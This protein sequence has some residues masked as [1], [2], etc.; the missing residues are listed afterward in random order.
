MSRPPSR[1]PLTALL[2]LALLGAPGCRR[3][4]ALRR[5]E[6]RFAG[7][8]LRVDSFAALKPDRIAA[9]ACRRGRVEGLAASLCSF[10]DARGPERT[11][12]L[13]D[14]FAEGAVTGVW[15]ERRDED[16]GRSVVLL[17]ADRDKVDLDGQVAMRILAAFRAAPR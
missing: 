11:A 3:D 2:A 10:D 7:A 9:V 17:L 1:A 15:A 8:G 4:K 16:D 13:G 14:L 5:A 12:N 6:E